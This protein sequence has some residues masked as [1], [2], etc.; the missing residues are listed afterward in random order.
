[1]NLET[2]V[3][4][5]DVGN[6]IDRDDLDNASLHIWKSK[7]EYLNKLIYNEDSSVNVEDVR[8]IPIYELAEWWN[9]QDDDISDDE[10]IGSISR[11]TWMG[12]CLI[13]K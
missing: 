3:V 1:M 9:A 4:L 13:K 8:F 7:E 6:N 12:Y 2:Y 5:V 10:N 11:K